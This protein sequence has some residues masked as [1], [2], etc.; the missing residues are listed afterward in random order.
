G[1]ASKLLRDCLDQ[2]RCS[3]GCGVDT[4]FFRPC[5][6]EPRRVVERSNSAAHG[7]RHEYLL[8]NPANHIEHDFPTLM[9]RA[10]VQEDKL[11]GAL[12]FIA[13]RHLY[14]V[15]GVA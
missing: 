2:F 7:E 11:V 5:L 13:A 4:Y 12:L 15:A 8:G 1:T 6:D 9:A 10:D 3:D 14:G